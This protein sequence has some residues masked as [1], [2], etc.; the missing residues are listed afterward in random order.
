VNRG[1]RR[2]LWTGSLACHT[3]QNV[4]DFVGKEFQL[5]ISGNEVYCTNALLLLIKIMPCSQLH[6]QKVSIKNTGFV[7]RSQHV[8]LWIVPEQRRSAGA[9]SQSSHTVE[10][11]PSSKVNLHHA[12]DFRSLRS[13]ELVT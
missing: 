13:A 4:T 8:N 11:D 9:L 2:S 6:C 7:L 12:I 10:H 5:K 1:A 3:R